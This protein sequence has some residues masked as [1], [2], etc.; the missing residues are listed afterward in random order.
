MQLKDSTVL[1]TGASEGIGRATALRLAAMG[2]HVIAASRSVPR[3]DSLRQ[4]IEADGRGSCEVLP[5]DLTRP[6]DALRRLEELSARVAVDVGI[7]NAGM[8]QYGPF[9][10]SPW[11]DIEPL[12]RLNIDGALATARALLP[13]MR[14]RRRGSIVLVSST[15]GKRAV[16]YNAAYCASKYALHGFGDALRLELRPYGI[17]V[18]VVC[19][20]RTDTAFFNRMAYSV[21]QGK[22]RRVPTSSPDRVADAVIRCV[23][24][25]RREIVVSPEGKL[26]AFVGSHFPRLTDTLLYHSVPRPSEE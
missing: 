4:T 23:R 21:P 12:L 25:R 20:A 1:V 9:A 2:C 6:E 11:K 24:R 22:S 15:L 5:I 10:A 26:F 7:V 8:G 13:G 3:L 17:H 16:P 14:E 19:P 18:G